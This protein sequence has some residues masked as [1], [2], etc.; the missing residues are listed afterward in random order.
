KKLS[1]ID[2]LL[3]KYFANNKFLAS[4]YYV[5]K[6]KFWRENRS[7]LYGRYQYNLNSKKTSGNLFSLRRNVHRIEKGI[8]MKPRRDVFAESYIDETVDNYISLNQSGES[9]TS[10]IWAHDVLTNYFDVVK[11]DKSL[12]IMSAKEKFLKSLDQNKQKP[13]L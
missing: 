6:P 10:L 7:V 12:K 13:E 2:L 5:F 4:I 3:L 11:L 8:L 1:K 9:S